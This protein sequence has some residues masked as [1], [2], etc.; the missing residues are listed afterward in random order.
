MRSPIGAKTFCFA[1]S[2]ALLS[3][4]T[5]LISAW[6]LLSAS[7]LFSEEDLSLLKDS[8]EDSSIFSLFLS[9][10]VLELVLSSLFSKSLV[11]SFIAFSRSNNKSIPKATLSWIRFK[12][13]LV[14]FLSSIT[15]SLSSFTLFSTFFV[16]FRKSAR[17]FSQIFNSSGSETFLE[18]LSAISSRFFLISVKIIFGSLS[19]LLLA[20]LT[21]F[22]TL[23]NMCK[24]IKI[25]K[26]TIN[27]LQKNIPIS[28]NESIIL[29]KMP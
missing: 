1:S 19:L 6:D 3:S 11:A 16:A 7:S 22:R 26:M 4:S 20:S 18:N 27:V 5:F 2:I 29:F 24:K 8:L 21:I 13:S 10:L 25:K 17:L 23:A 14:K 12:S 9:S 15:F 28:I